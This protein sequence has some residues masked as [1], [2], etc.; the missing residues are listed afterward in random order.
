[1]NTGL[2]VAW[3]LLVLCGVLQCGFCIR[4]TK[5]PRV[6]ASA[7]TTV[8]SKVAHIVELEVDHAS[9]PLY[10]LMADGSVR[11]LVKSALDSNLVVLSFSHDP[12]NVPQGKQIVKVLDE[13]GLAAHR[14]AQRSGEEGAEPNP[15]LTFPLEIQG[16]YS[17]PWANSEFIALLVSGLV[18]YVAFSADRRF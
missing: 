15:V 4:L 3:L 1:M 9:E 2:S 14:R 10:A 11:A 6:Y 7:D 13:A 12:S 5:E 18:F 8:G 16:G 17:G